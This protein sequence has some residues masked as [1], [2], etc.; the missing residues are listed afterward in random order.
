MLIARDGGCIKPCCTVGAYGSQV[1]HAVRDWIEGGN[2]NVDEMA[3]ACGPD[4]RAATDGGYRTSINTRG[5]CE[6]APPEHLDNGQ[7]RVNY[8]HRPEALLRPPDDA[9]ANKANGDT[10]SGKGVRGP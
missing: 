9:S 8:F 4:N 3:L 5:E 2:T 7:A 10:V 1:H 6:W